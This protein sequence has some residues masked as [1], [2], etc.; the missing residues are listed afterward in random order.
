MSD[1]LNPFGSPPLVTA[2]PFQDPHSGPLS[3]ASN[4]HDTPGNYLSDA[5]ASPDGFQGAAWT[6]GGARDIM[7]PRDARVDSPRRR[8]PDDEDDYGS[9]RASSG[10]VE[11]SV[12]A[13]QP[14]AAFV[15][16][17][18]TGID[19]NRRDMYIKFNAESNLPSFR[20]ST[21][22]AVSRS[23]TEFTAYLSA[24]SVTCPQSIM[25]ALP[26]P[27]T[28]AASD[29]E[30]DRILKQQYQKWVV[31]LMQDQAVVRDEETRSFVE[32][33]FGYTPNHRKKSATSFPSFSRA[34]KGG[35]L[36]DPLTLSKI[37]MARLETN[38]LDAS[39]TVERVSKTRRQAATSV[40]EL[41]DQI[42]TFA[43]SETYPPLANAFKRL[44]RT[45]KVDA[46]LLAV[47]SIN[48]LVHLGDSLLYQ[49]SNAKSAKETLSNRDSVSEE[50][51]TAVKTTIQKR[52]NIE[53]LRSSAKELRSDKVDEALEELDEAKRYETLLTARLAAISSSLSP[54]LA[55]HSVQT[56]SDLLSTLVDHAK[57]NLV[58]EK[59]RLK[60]Y[61]TLRTEM[62]NIR[63]LEAGVVY[64]VHNQQTGMTRSTSSATVPGSH[65][66]HPTSTAQSSAMS[67][68]VSN[69]SSTS[70]ATQSG[71]SR[72]PSL[73]PL[74]AHSGPIEPG[75]GVRDLSSMA[76]KAQKRSVRSMASSVVVEGDR[77]QRVDARMA[78]S[79]LAN[80]F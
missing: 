28:S 31:R 57:S 70:A 29:E 60:E 49:S 38:F 56:H 40:N 74:A 61:E 68:T 1:P 62:K 78:A 5:Q 30:D 10:G 3:T 9:N 33:D 37:T 42:N 59:Q 73:D 47:Q 20:N 50:H 34:S 32:S 12:P 80:G 71:S 52:R 44:A 11:P 51:R 4:S 19:R 14:E 58:Y 21:Y 39:K 48:E 43:M 6:A 75:A 22:R 72:G 27:Q 2:S 25:P 54:S 55:R 41:G 67:S 66:R 64:H 26:L 23:Y 18:I 7:T 36:D 76:Q 53:K 65:A 46:D 69:S 79:M 77:K 16:I 8:I 35:E 13:K 63:K 15:R 24:L 17:R 45:M